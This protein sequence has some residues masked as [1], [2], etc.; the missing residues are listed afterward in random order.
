MKGTRLFLTCFNLWFV[1]QVDYKAVE[2]LLKNMDPLNDNVT[3]ML[4]QSSDKFV[5][6]LWKDGTTTDLSVLRLVA[7]GLLVLTSF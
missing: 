6:E 7:L 3:T 4:N 2:W 1:F 5:S